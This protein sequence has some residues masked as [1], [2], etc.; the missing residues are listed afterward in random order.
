MLKLI[1]YIVTIIILSGIHVTY[2]QQ[3]PSSTHYLVNP[4]ALSPSL[5]GYTGY[6]E[7]FLNYRN[8]WTKIEGGPRTFSANGFGNVYQQKMW[9]GGELM[10]DKTDILSVFKANLS[11]TYKLQVDNNQFLYFGIWGTYY[12]AS[13]NTGNGIGVDPNDPIIQNN[14][15]L[16]SSAFNAG[17]GIVYNWN[18]LNIG[19]SMPSMFGSNDEYEL[20]NAFK[21]KVQ[22]QFQIHASYMF[23]LNKEWQLQTIGVFR[24]TGNQ[25]ATVEVSAMSIYRGRFWGGLLYRNGGVLAINLGGHI[26]NGLTFNYSYEIGLGGINKASGGSHEVTIGYRFKFK[27]TNYFGN[28]DSGNKKRKG[29]K[30]GAL[31]YPEVKDF[32]YR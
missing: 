7:V 32:N 3:L 25:P 5:A 19:L 30:S 16:N 27:D 26:Y 4:Y 15:K 17:F 21:Y 28:T 18:K 9:V 31:N 20:N 29:R 2:A 10:A 1:K 22:R 6:S 23:D 12:Q 14:S 11:W 8:D 13:A 24:K